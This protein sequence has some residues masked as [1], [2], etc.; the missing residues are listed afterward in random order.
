VRR[1]LQRRRLPTA[2]GLAYRVKPAGEDAARS[3]AHPVAGKSR[4]SLRGK[5]TCAAERGAD[6]SK[7][8][9]NGECPLWVINGYRRADHRC[10]LYPQS[11]HV[12]RQNRYPLKCQDQTCYP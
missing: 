3:P 12:Q 8:H 7:R 6:S 9:V 11:R 10:P 4:R 5:G 1:S 2:T